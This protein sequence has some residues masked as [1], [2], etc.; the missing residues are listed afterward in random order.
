MKLL[1]A[2]CLNLNL[3][4]SESL[5]AFLRIVS[6][7]FDVSIPAILEMSIFLD[8]PI[9]KLSSDMVTETF[10]PIRLE[11][12]YAYPLDSASLTLLPKGKWK[13]SL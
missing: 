11:I 3:N 8:I 9:M 4:I 10:T 2:V 13:I 5:I 7:S 1:A 12:L 6:R